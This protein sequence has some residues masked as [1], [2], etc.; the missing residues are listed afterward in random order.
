MTSS[1][2]NRVPRAAEGTILDLSTALNSELRGHTPEGATE[3]LSA[4]LDQLSWLLVD[5]TMVAGDDTAISLRMLLKRASAQGV[6]I[7]L[8]LNWQPQHWG[9]APEAPPTA[10]VLRRFRTLAEAAALISASTTEAA[11][12]FQ[13]SD[14]VSIHGALSQRP[15]VLITDSTGTLHWCLGGRSGRL[16]SI[17]HPDVFLRRLLEGLSRHPELLGHAGPGVD[18]VARPDPL[19]DLL[20]QA[21]D[22]S[23]D[24]SSDRSSDSSSDSPPDSD[25]TSPTPSR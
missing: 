14:P 21:A 22:S 10:E 19:A 12:F 4:T 24:S 25:S 6:S 1:T 2:E 23:S 8:E 11:W 17:Q 3:R 7:A 20:R 13:S 18:A 15:A 16:E 5:S 9:L